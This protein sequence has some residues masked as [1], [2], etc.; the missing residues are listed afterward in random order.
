MKRT[1]TP[2][3]AL[4]GGESSLITLAQLLAEPDPDETLPALRTLSDAEID[5]ALSYLYINV[6]PA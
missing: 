4:N 1:L 3:R 2:A 5:A 6:V